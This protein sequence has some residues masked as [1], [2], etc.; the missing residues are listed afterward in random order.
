[1]GHP[2]VLPRSGLFPGAL[3]SPWSLAHCYSLEHLSRLSFPLWTPRDTTH[4]PY[5]YL[6]GLDYVLTSCQVLG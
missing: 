4:S 3:Q 5:T 6:L 2:G 1:M